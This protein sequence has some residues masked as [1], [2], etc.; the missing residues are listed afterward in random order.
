MRPWCGLGARRTFAE[1]SASDA[2]SAVYSRR[3]VS[4]GAIGTMCSF[5]TR[6][7][8]TGNVR[9]PTLTVAPTTP[10][11]STAAVPLF[12]T[13][14]PNDRSA[15][16][17]GSPTTSCAYAKDTW[18][19]AMPPA[20][21]APAS[22]RA[23]PSSDSPPPPPQEA[24]TALRPSNAG[25]PRMIVEKSKP[26]APTR[27]WWC[28][29]PERSRR[30]IN[31]TPGPS[32]PSAPRILELRP[33]LAMT[34]DGARVAR[35]WLF[36]RGHSKSPGA[37]TGHRRM[38]RARDVDA[39]G[40]RTRLEELRRARGAVEGHTSAPLASS[41]NERLT[42]SSTAKTI[43]SRSASGA[44]PGRAH[45]RRRAGALSAARAEHAEAF[46]KG[47]GCSTDLR[48]PAA[49]PAKRLS[50]RQTS[51]AAR[52][53][54]ACEDDAHPALRYEDHGVVAPAI[55][56]GR[57]GQR[58]IVRPRKQ[59]DDAGLGG[60]EGAREGRD[61]ATGKLLSS[62]PAGL[63]VAFDPDTREVFVGTPDHG[64]VLVTR[65]D[66]PPDVR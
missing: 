20:L 36:S 7:Q 27:E 22:V 64:V 37:P 38:T 41:H 11:P 29:W 66:F 9:S 24:S 51:S 30:L 16:L 53:S 10:K 18:A 46:A 44:R 55:H 47:T 56:D 62:A 17:G 65:D 58:K 26:M 2:I 60:L 28:C 23:P 8:F 13:F 6:A 52:A 43:G 61:V 12:S 33:T 42:P 39:A 59:D 49:A 48:K 3:R 15:A 14:M 31:L 54:A 1:H 35:R 50:A 19:V 25:M 34:C 5:D 4:P 63:A 45:H 57:R 21:S 40:A 32:W